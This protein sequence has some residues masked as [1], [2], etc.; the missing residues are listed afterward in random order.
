MVDRSLLALVIISMG[1]FILGDGRSGI[2]GSKG[3]ENMWQG[4]I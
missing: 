3:L 2:L 4:D 1:A